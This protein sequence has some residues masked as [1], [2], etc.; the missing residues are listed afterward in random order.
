M[1]PHPP[2]P[3]SSAAGDVEAFTLTVSIWCNCLY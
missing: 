1:V 3:L 2:S